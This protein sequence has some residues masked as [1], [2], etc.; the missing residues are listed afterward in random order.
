[1]SRPVPQ[2][3]SDT[4]RQILEAALRRFAHSG[5]AGASVQAIVDEA[6]VTKPALYYHFGSK[7]GI[8]TALIDWAAG[9]RWRRTEQAAANGGTLQEK[10]T[11]IVETTFDF[12][13]QNRELTRLSMG[14]VFAAPGEVPNPGH[15]MEKGRQIFDLIQALAESARRDGVV[16]A[17]YSAQELAMGVYGTMNIHVMLHLVMPERPLNHALAARIVSLFMSGAAANGGR[18]VK[19]A[20]RRKA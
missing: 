6:R 9:E 12:V 5:Y 2:H 15:C 7:A 3:A 19:P 11:A 8:Y 20:K 17:E 4:R 1:M 14:A 16:K 13:R 18:R 10:L